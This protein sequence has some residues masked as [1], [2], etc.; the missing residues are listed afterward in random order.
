[1]SDSQQCRSTK[2]CAGIALTLYV[3]LATAGD[4][5][6]ERFD[7]SELRTAEVAEI[8]GWPLEPDAEYTVASIR[9]V[10]QQIF[11]TDDAAENRPLFRFANRWHV[12]T[13]EGT[14]RTLLLFG[15]GDK[16]D[17]SRLAETE[18]ALRAKR[19]LYDARVIANRVCG[20]DVDIVVVTR[21]IWSLH[22]TA[23]VTRTGGE[24]EYDLGFSERNIFGT[25]VEVDAELFKT[26]DRSG[27]SAGFTNPNLGNS[28]VGLGLRVENTDEGDGVLAFIGQ[29]F[30][31]LDTRRAWNLTATTSESRRRLYDAGEEISS[32]GLDYRRAVLSRGWSKGLVDGVANRLSL[33]ATFEEWAFSDVPGS[34]PDLENREFAY[35]FVSFQRI[36]D[37]FSRVRNLNRVQTTEDVFL[38][39]QYD[40]LLGYSPRQG[41]VVY[42]A[43][44][45][46]GRSLR[47]EISDI[48]LYGAQ[49]AGFWNRD[50][51]R[52]E[53]LIA[54]VWA[55][56]RRT[57]TPRWGLFVDAEATVT[58][59]LTPDQQILTG[60]D[61]GMRGYPN[62]FQAGA[63]RFRITAEER[64]YSGIYLWRVVRIAGAAFVDIGR[65]WDS[66]RDNPVLA[67]VGFGLRFE[68]TRTD[69][70]RVYHIDFAF[71]VVDRP[72]TRGVEIT[73]TG[74][75]S[76]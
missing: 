47:G 51:G 44:F 22:P 19:F 1:M 64:Y 26:L 63:H 69:R 41:H 60:G 67:N 48:L 58:D 27:A 28:R 54:Q 75:R 62:R 20:N 3:S 11:N 10:R 66:A 70:G 59:Q 5:C 8:E 53:N 15:D 30:Y 14:I 74:K 36:G 49:V 31:A 43:A 55:R 56:Y 18:R 76:L 68:S 52:A 34:L 13:K 35:P 24:N 73:L 71:P 7:D 65:A 40:L 29:P 72:G 16:V 50:N 38:G 37:D 17:V 6:T 12:N 39:R 42:N 32:F 25:G 45:R 61:S 2:T 23:S 9:I 57:Q 21:D 46:D 4:P 33:G